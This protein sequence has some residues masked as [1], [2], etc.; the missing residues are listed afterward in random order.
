MNQILTEN[1]V[2][3]IFE[4]V[5]AGDPQVMLAKEFGVTPQVISEIMTGKSWGRVTGKVLKTS[6]RCKLTVE[7]VL[8]I[9][10][11][12]RSGVTNTA[13]AADYAVSVQAISNIRTGRNWFSVTGRVPARRSDRG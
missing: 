5:N 3:T 1:D 12:I 6:P 2:R 13:I 8:D 9:D 11:Q 10:A 4:A 7:D